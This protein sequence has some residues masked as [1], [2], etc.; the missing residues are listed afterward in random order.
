MQRQIVG[1]RNSLH[2]I[3]KIGISERLHVFALDKGVVDADLHA[4]PGGHLCD[5]SSDVAKAQK[6]QQP[7]FYVYGGVFVADIEV[8]AFCFHTALDQILAAREQQR[9][10]VLRHRAG[11]GRRA[12]NHGDP[13]LRR[14]FDIHVVIADAGSCDDLQIRTLLDGLAVDLADAQ[15]EGVGVTQNIDDLVAVTVVGNDQLCFSFEHLHADMVKRMRDNNLVHAFSSS[16]FF[17][18]TAILAP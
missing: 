18:A 5:Q 16:A 8:S 13:A 14:R 10:R 1:R 4:D 9:Q 12:E 11:V 15:D 6:H 17:L 2:Q 7:I 3:I